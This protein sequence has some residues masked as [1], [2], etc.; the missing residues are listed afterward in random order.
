MRADA[1]YVCAI[2]TQEKERKGKQLIQGHK[3]VHSEAGAAFGANG[4]IAKHL[5][6]S[7]VSLQ[8]D[9]YTDATTKAYSME[10]SSSTFF[11]FTRSI[12]KSP[13]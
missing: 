10:V 3:Q 11:C 2:A 8:G 12:M 5:G 7:A 13:D 1:V 4:M 9:D 6:R